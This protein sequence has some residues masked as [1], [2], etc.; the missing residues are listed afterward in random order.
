MAVDELYSNADARA[1]GENL[2][3]AR[4]RQKLTQQG[5][6]DYVGVTRQTVISWEKGERLPSPTDLTTV[7]GLYGTTVHALLQPRGAREPISLQLRG[8]QRLDAALEQELERKRDEFQQ[9]CEDYVAL[10]QMCAAP[11]PPTRA[12]TYSLS[13]AD[14]HLLAEEVA[15]AERNR[16]GLGDHPIIDLRETLEREG[17]RIF[18]MDLPS[19]ISGFYGATAELGPCMA[20]NR[21]H[22]FERQRWS[23]PHEY[24]HFLTNRFRADIA[25]FYAYQ[26]VP[27]HERFA[28][29]FARS[30]LMPTSS[31]VR[32]FNDV[33]RSRGR[34]LPADLCQMADYFAVSL[35]AMALRLEGLH[36]IK[37]GTY[38]ALID[39][40][41]KPEQAKGQLDIK[42]RGADR[43]LLPLRYRYLA[44]EALWRGLI[45]EDEYAN[46]LRT[47]LVTA[48]H[49]ARALR[50]RT[51]QSPSGE[52]GEIGLRLD[53][54]QG[55]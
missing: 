12:P 44:T 32:Q 51:T 2:R 19:R 8:A 33:K 26:D 42:P 28:D 54:A 27:E 43:A 45:S 30:F 50:T 41:F 14:P 18:F 9:L 29:A 6:A 52:V 1:I 55:A 3:A 34:V 37:K 21:K 36:L 47:D 38:Q 10:E 49:A 25:V 15:S 24:A 35:E 4:E 23:L 53:D 7:A 17:I 20:I 5:I 46:F 39:G 31:V 22:P 13:G 48:R 11:S 16:L 40:G